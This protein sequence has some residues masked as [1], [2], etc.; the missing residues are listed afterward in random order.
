MLRGTVVE[1]DE[2]VGLGTVSSDE[3]VS[4]RFHM[5]EVADGTRTID[6]GQSVA[7][8]LLPKFGRYEAGRL[9]KV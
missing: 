6:V 2:A 4:Y 8:E 7:F 1:F 3:G 5:I 9:Q